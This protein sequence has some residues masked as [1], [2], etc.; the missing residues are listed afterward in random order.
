LT[1]EPFVYSELYGPVTHVHGQPIAVPVLLVDLLR[2]LF[3]GGVYM[4]PVI[5]GKN[6]EY[7]RAGA[8]VTVGRAYS[9]LVVG[10]DWL[11]TYKGSDGVQHRFLI[12]DSLQFRICDPASIQVLT[13]DPRI[14]PDDY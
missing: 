12:V 9:R 11:T 14:Y 4:A 7:H 10:Q 1:V 3:R 2:N 13:A 8:I 6:D 5:N